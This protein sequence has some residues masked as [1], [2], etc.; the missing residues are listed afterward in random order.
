MTPGPGHDHT[1]THAITRRPGENLGQGLTTSN[2]GAPDPALADTQFERYVRALEDCG[3]AVTILE[4]LPDHPDA[5]FV[6]DTAVV[7]R[8]VAVI[9]RPGAASRLDEARHMAPILDRHR[10]LARIEAPGTL[11]G[12]DVLMIDDH[13]L[14]GISD[15]TNEAGARQLGAILTARGHTWQAVPVV[16]GLHLKS[17]VNYLGNDTLLLTEGFAASAALA[18][19]DRIVVDEG[20]AYSCNTLLLND[21]LLMPA[22][23]PGTRRRLASL[24]REIVELDTSEFRKMD[25]GLTCLS[26]RF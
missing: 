5:H 7:T 13:V 6:E 24:G 26:L 2:L 21:R 16:S 12:G 10:D 17:S 4:P 22:G 14:I 3:L 9:A 20:E 25:G 8:G 19:Y 18:A 1:F 15:R 23:F 11:D